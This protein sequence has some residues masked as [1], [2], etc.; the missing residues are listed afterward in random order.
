MAGAMPGVPG[1]RGPVGIIGA[2]PAGA[3]AA[4]LLAAGGWEVLLF[5]P[6]APWEKPCGGGIPAHGFI[7]FPELRELE[8]RG[9]WAR[10]ARLIG[11]D[12]AELVVE[13]GAPILLVDRR[14][15]SA[16]QLGRAE[17]AGARRVRCRILDVTRAEHG[18]RLSGDDGRAYDV[19]Y[20]IGADGATSRMRRLLA[21]DFRPRLTPTRGR[22]VPVGAGADPEI[23][24]WFPPDFRGY[25]WEFPRG[26]MWSVGVCHLDHGVGKSRLEGV[27][28]EHVAARGGSM[29][30]RVYG[31]PI[32]L[33]NPGDYD[34]PEWFGGEDWALCGDAAALVDPISGEGIHH[35][36][37]SG[38]L[39]ARALLETGSLAAY[40]GFLAA[41]VL[42][43][44]RKAAEY[45][46]RFYERGFVEALLRVC[47]RGR[48][49]R[50]VLADVMTGLQSYRTLR[51]RTAWAYVLDGFPA[52]STLVP[53]VKFFR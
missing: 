43:E 28:G 37:R 41:E 39:A 36:L 13:T 53:L 26:R 50:G 29:E 17:V 6:K 12:G 8:G 38:Q 31:H 2:G 19:A 51:L 11:P 33:P 44:L 23:V 18:W 3:R 45:A 42:P 30:H 24:V 27:L 40:R 16:Y 49:M 14:I 52:P 15:L 32:P 34:R 20:L 10:R 1:R 47:G 48:R 35:A 46:S 21:P 7:H 5:D 25:V 9:R 4:E 22:F